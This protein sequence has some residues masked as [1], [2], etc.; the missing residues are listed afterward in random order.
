MLHLYFQFKWKTMLLNTC[1]SSDYW[2]V[3]STSQPRPSQWTGWT[4]RTDSAHHFESNQSV[5]YD[6]VQE[7]NFE[8][9]KFFE[10]ISGML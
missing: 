10:K 7:L 1:Q 6:K 8:Y 9:Q 2:A 4:E 5:I 3:M